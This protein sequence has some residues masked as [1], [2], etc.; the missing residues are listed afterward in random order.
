VAD[1]IVKHVKRLLLHG[2][3][4]RKL[5]LLELLTNLNDDVQLID[6]K[7]GS[8][9]LFYLCTLLTGL[10]YL[11]ELHISG[12]LQQLLHQVFILLMNDGGVINVESFSWKMSEYSTSV[13]YMCSLR[14]MN[15]F[16]TVYTLAVETPNIEPDNDA[17]SL[18]FVGF[19]SELIELVLIKT[20][21]KLYAI[22][23]MVI[24]SAEV[25]T[26]ATLSAV[27]RHW[28]QTLISRQ[29]MKRVMQRYFKRMCSPFKCRPHLMQRL[30]CNEDVNGMAEFNN[31][32]YVVCVKSSTVQVFNS[33]PPFSRHTDIEVRG[34]ND[35]RDIVVCSETSQLYIADYEQC[36]IW[37]V[38][39]L[40][41]KQDDQLISTQWKPRSLSTKS[42]RLLITPCN[43][44]VL[45]IYGDDGVLL[46]HSQLPHYMVATHA[47]E[48]THNTY[49]VSHR[50][51]LGAGDTLL[52][53]HE[54]VSEIDINGRVVRIFNSQHNDIGSIQ[55][56][57][58]QYL[59]LAG[60]NHVIV[61]DRFNERIVV[62]NED[63]QLKRVLINS[64][65]G[66]QPWR[67][68]LNQ[69]TGLL[70]ISFFNSAE[71]T[72]YKIAL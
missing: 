43:G 1:R 49:I 25:Y 26:L 46:K 32:L 53:E 37:R 12:R 7:R 71:V 20:V 38:N 4:Q 31:K 18:S 63:L 8:I 55:F 70:F 51:R 10:Q 2:S 47:V 62:L 67:L 52:S 42:R 50:S 21:G 29:Y 64:S 72:I 34:L 16:S 40:S 33:S 22:F 59:A 45:F 9:E 5:K 44:D 56:N 24:P 61:A 3:T 54:S 60:K 14:G 69:L 28:Y 36:A 65:H 15:V 57:Q 11:Y 68:C 27:S 17:T 30:H 23:N 13:K 66:Q 19:P 41:Y 58:P 6:V 35:P 39:L 48:T